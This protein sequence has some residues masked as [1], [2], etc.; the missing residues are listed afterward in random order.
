MSQPHHVKAAE[1]HGAA[2]ESHRKA[3]ELH[4]KN[5]H[6]TGVEHAKKA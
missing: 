6:K 5:D 4:G 2:V 1:L 3:A